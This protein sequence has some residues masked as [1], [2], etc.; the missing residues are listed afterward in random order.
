[1]LKLKK[2]FVRMLI[3]FSFLP[4]SIA[5]AMPPYGPAD[6][7]QQ[8]NMVEG[9]A[10]VRIWTDSIDPLAMVR[11]GLSEGARAGL[12]EGTTIGHVTL[13]TA[14]AYFSLW[15]SEVLGE[16]FTVTA[17]HHPDYETDYNKEKKVPEH[18]FI[19][20]TDTEAID[21]MFAYYSTWGEN[22][23]WYSLGSPLISKSTP[24]QIDTSKHYFNCATF[25]ATALTA[26]DSSFLKDAK[27]FLDSNKKK[28]ESLEK[29][30][31]QYLPSRL[32]EGLPSLVNMV[33]AYKDPAIILPTD[34]LGI[35][36]SRMRTDLMKIPPFIRRNG[37]DTATL[38]QDFIDWI[39]R[40]GNC[41][42]QG[43]FWKA[44]C[45]S[46][47]LEDDDGQPRLFLIEVEVEESS[48]KKI[49][50]GE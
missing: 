27:G 40:Y 15:P 37:S 16:V 7:L 46:L 45:S 35:L 21:T 17:K 2:F 23:Q 48:R 29:A 10:K 38:K 4:F 34:L 9:F 28:S 36:R 24:I 41:T 12:V 11:T 39:N 8:E 43:E 44:V 25:V 33:V 30:I 13:Q 6:F 22:L 14:N 20:K 1:M 19:L 49:K 5:S 50:T 47:S 26:A 42:S 32:Q 18:V 31:E 3:V